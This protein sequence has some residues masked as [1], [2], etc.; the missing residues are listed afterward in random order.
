MNKKLLVAAI[1]AA[2]AAGSMMAQAEVKLY[3]HMHASLDNVDL[4]GAPSTGKWFLADNFTR[5]GIRISEDL[6]GGL[7]AIGQYEFTAFNAG[8]GADA[9][10]RTGGNCGIGTSAG[11]ACSTAANRDHY[12]GLEGGFGSIRYGQMDSTLKDARKPLDNF[13]GEALGEPRPVLHQGLF[14]GRVENSVIYYSPK[15]AGAQIKAQYGV[16]DTLANDNKDT[17]IGVFGAAGPLSYAIAY[18]TKDVTGGTEDKMSGYRLAGSYDLGGGLT[19]GA[20]WQ[21]GSDLRGVAGEDRDSF[22]VSAAYRFGNNRIKGHFV[23]A[24]E[25]D[26]ATATTG[27]G[28]DFIAVGWDHF[29]SKTAIGY[30]N[31]AKVSNDSNAQ[32]SLAGG[33]GT[34]HGDQYTPALGRDG[35]GFAVGMILDF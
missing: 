30:I 22:G 24:D 32:F 27:G 14:D 15:F 5:F 12:V 2:I 34:G 23:Q 6:G 4:D 9:A 17:A 35:S 7:K 3:G 33:P 10:T 21:S 20:L 11:S 28:A 31:F 16:E 25:A 1:G 13:Y 29:F 19:V 8:G 18:Q 26:N